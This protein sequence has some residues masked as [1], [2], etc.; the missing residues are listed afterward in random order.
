MHGAA[1]SS[2]RISRRRTCWCGTTRRRYWS[3]R[4]G[5]PGLG[6]DSRGGS[7]AKHPYV[8]PEQL[9]AD[10]A[11][12]GPWTD[13]YSLAGLIYLA[14]SGKAPPAASAR[15]LHDELT[16]AA[17]PPKGAIATISWLPSIPVCSSARGI[18]LRP[19]LRGATRRCGPTLAADRRQAASC[20]RAGTCGRSRRQDDCCSGSMR[21]TEERPDEEARPPEDHGKPRLPRA[22]LRHCRLTRRRGRR[23]AGS[24]IVASILR[25]ECF[26][27]QCIGPILPVMAT[28]ARW[29]AASSVSSPP[30]CRPGSGRTAGFER[31]IALRPVG[32]YT[33]GLALGKALTRRGPRL[34]RRRGAIAA[35]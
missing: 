27:D 13:I 6:C 1:A 22:V 8:A 34:R 25:P 23:C 19:L 3:T 35:A 30:R 32:C 12:I 15:M 16:P 20:R 11:H 21:S 28:S 4:F 29:P 17:S 2:T 26:G 33:K 14:I 5:L 7:V 10:G 24:I 31:E 9:M 18:G